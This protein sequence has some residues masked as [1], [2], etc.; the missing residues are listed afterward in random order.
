MN[1]L[2]PYPMRIRALIWLGVIV[3]SWALAIAAGVGINHALL[4]MGR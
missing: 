4:L 2:K 3:V 1:E